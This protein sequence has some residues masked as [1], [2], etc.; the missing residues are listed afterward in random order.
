[1]KIH[2]KWWQFSGT[3]VLI[4]LFI[5]LVIFAL[6]IP[7]I[8]EWRVAVEIEETFPEL[9]VYG[10]AYVEANPATCAEVRRDFRD[11]R[12]HSSTF[13]IVVYACEVDGGI[14][15]VTVR[16]HGRTP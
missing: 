15:S 8:L 10:R 1:M 2:R 12:W 9:P 7:N 6:L 5:S 14:V 4:V 13:Y 16:D 3:E 11:G